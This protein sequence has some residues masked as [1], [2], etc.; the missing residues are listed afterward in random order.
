MMRTLLTNKVAYFQTS[1][2][3]YIFLFLIIATIIVK[4]LLRDVLS[5]VEQTNC[6]SI[7]LIGQVRPK[8][9]KDELHNF[10][11]P[12]IASSFTQWLNAISS[13][14]FCLSHSSFMGLRRG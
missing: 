7:V 11:K 5:A 1:P 6:V 10:T 9:V 12:R 3:D 14:W 13:L 8:L 2:Q 4:D